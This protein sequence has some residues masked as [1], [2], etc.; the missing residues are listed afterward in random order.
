MISSTYAKVF[1][2]NLV[3]NLDNFLTQGFG[4]KHSACLYDYVGRWPSYCRVLHIERVWSTIVSFLGAS[5]QNVRREVT[6]TASHLCRI[7]TP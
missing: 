6:K 2:A 7:Y 1:F 5:V 4:R 3:E